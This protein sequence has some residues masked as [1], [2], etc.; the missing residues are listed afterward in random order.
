MGRTALVLTTDGGPG[1]ASIAA[2]VCAH[3]W[4][5][6]R[7]ERNRGEKRNSSLHATARYYLFFPEDLMR[8]K[9][10]STV[11]LSLLLGAA[12][13]S[14]SIHSEPSTGT[15]GASV[16]VAGTGGALGVGG[17]TTNPGTGGAASGKGGG[18]A[19]AP[20]GTGGFLSG[21]GGQISSGGQVGSGGHLATGGQVGSGGQVGTGGQSAKGGASGTGGAVA[22]G[23]QQAS[24]GR[25]PGGTAGN[26]TGGSGGSTGGVGGMAGAMSGGASGPCDIYE[27]AG[28]PCVAAHSTVRALYG[29]Y[30][31]PLYQVS[32]ASDNA[33]KDIP[34]LV[35]GGFANSPLQD[36]FCTG[37][38]CTIPIIYDQSPHS[39]HL[40]VTWFANW[41]PN[42]GK[43][44]AAAAAKITVGG[45]TVYGIK[46]TS[47]SDI[48]YRTGISL[49]GTASVSNG[50]STVTFS[51]P[52]TLAKGTPLMFVAELSSCTTY[53]CPYYSVAAATTASTTATLTANYKGTSN[54]A[55]TAW[56]EGTEGVA[57][58]DEPEGIYA[59]LDGT[60]HNAGCCFDYGNSE[61]NGVD[62]GAATMEALYWGADTQ[63]GESGGGSG[64]WVGADLEN[65]LSFGYANGSAKVSTNTSVSF[66]YVTAM[67][68]GLSASQC[69]SG[70][71]S[72]GCFELKAGNA[73]SGALAVK[74]DATTGGYGARPPGYTPMKKTGGIILGTGGDGSASGTGTWFEGAMTTGAPPDSADNDVQANVVAAG[75]G[76]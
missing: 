11:A 7:S 69:P 72:S 60:S 21:T 19:G 35:A 67:L 45:H 64:P 50:S 30:N 34:V 73:Q 58:G 66:S 2:H 59:V 40:R 68:K 55:T 1:P 25:G 52:Q 36:S 23:G 28:T 29:A 46:V 20:S 3:S 76:H 6:A 5:V 15:G 38:T 12:G 53:D 57:T 62:D 63:F 41:L 17:A 51:S 8:A 37:T 47:G 10:V 42:G 70:L 32:R 49:S 27:A 43:P 48:A 26:G 24:G 75:Y 18:A 9:Q 31:G 71:T 16:S 44:A 4:V 61:I 33:T 54:A 65:G 74:F 14:N 13:C 39:N 22:A 56:N